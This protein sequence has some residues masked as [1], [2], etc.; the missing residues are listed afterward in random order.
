MEENN[1]VCPWCDTEIVWDE[2]IG[3]EEQCPHCL[4]ELGNY[5]TMS[6]ELDQEDEENEVKNKTKNIK[7][8]EE[9]EDR[10]TPILD[11]FISQMETEPKTE[12]LL[13][14]EQGVYHYRRKQE[15]SFECSNCHDFMLLVGDHEVKKDDFIPYVPVSQVQGVLQAPYKMNLYICPSCF[16][17]KAVLSEQDRISMMNVLKTQQDNS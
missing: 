13:Q 17:M 1:T 8:D 10:S 4:N 14:Y 5:R 12:D 6:V 15:E 7:Q 9:K 3:K 11:S 2:E 16:E